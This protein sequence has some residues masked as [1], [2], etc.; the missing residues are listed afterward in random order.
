MTIKLIYGS[1]IAL[2]NMKLSISAA[3]AQVILQVHPPPHQRAERARPAATLIF[4]MI[5][6]ML[7][8]IQASDI[9]H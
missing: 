9:V 3:S 8:R 2:Q 7:E 6:I 4:I 1:I 5:V